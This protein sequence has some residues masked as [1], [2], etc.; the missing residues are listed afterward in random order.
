MESS[1][2]LLCD[3][4]RIQCGFDGCTAVLFCWYFRS[5]CSSTCSVRMSI[6]TSLNGN[7]FFFF[8]LLLSE[9][10]GNLLAAN[11]EEEEG[12]K[13]K[14]L[15]RD[16]TGIFF[17]MGSCCRS[18]VALLPLLHKKNGA[19]TFFFLCLLMCFFFICCSKIREKVET[20]GGYLLCRGKVKLKAAVS[21]VSSTCSGRQMNCFHRSL[22]RSSLLHRVLNYALGLHLHDNV[23]I[24]GC[25]CLFINPAFKVQLGEDQL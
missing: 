12:N 18:Y 5:R 11:S 10:G 19:T 22:F 17:R 23:P 6:T 7:H 3:W 1:A 16:A 24:W 21:R 2:N 20:V 4:W 13:W 8:F 9:I 25:D 14:C 15:E